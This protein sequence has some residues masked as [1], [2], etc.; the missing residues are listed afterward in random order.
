MLENLAAADTYEAMI[1]PVEAPSSWM[2]RDACGQNTGLSRLLGQLRN[3][4]LMRQL[5]NGV[6]PVPQ[7][8]VQ[9]RQA[10]AN[11]PGAIA[12]MA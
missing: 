11:T 12:V 8:R 9:A 2:P 4:R 7:V 3:P 10:A 1:Y 5:R 6:R